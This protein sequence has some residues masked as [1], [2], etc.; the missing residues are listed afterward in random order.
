MWLVPIAG[1]LTL[2]IEKPKTPSSIPPPTTERDPSVPPLPGRDAVVLAAL[3]QVGSSDAARYWA[4]VMPGVNAGKLDW[5][6]AF[7]LW[8]LHQ[9]GLALDRHWV[10]GKGFILV[11]PHPLPTTTDPKPGDIAYFNHNQHQAIVSAVTA[12]GV[13]LVNGNGS[14]GKVSISTV[15][16][17]AVTAFFSIEPLLH[18]P[19]GNA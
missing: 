7:A 19:A 5:C 8:C 3:S 1:L 14:A 17:S 18:Q 12:S 16:K 2:M 4:D 11:G 10:I 9:A 15:P 6:G 13:E